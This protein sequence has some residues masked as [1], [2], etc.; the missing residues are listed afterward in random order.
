[1]KLTI[2]RTKWLRGAQVSGSYLLEP[3]HVGEKMCC[4]G[5]LARAY[6]VPEEEIRGLRSPTELAAHDLLPQGMEFLVHMVH[7]A[8]LSV[9]IGSQ[10]GCDLMT[11]NDAKE[12]TDIE[13]E[14]RLVKIFKEHDIDVE[15]IN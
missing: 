7:G 3:R 2:D 1:M 8:L 5:F 10:A 6:D 15:F 13:R 9:P 11:A 4:L 12:L 14:D